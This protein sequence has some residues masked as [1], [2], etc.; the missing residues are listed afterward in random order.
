MNDWQSRVRRHLRE[1]GLT[2][3]DAV[4][5][6][7]ADHLEDAWEARRRR[8]R[9][10]T[11]GEF[12]A[13]ALRRADVMALAARQATPPPP[14]APEPGIRFA[15]SADWAANCA[16]RCGCCAGRRRSPP[17]SSPS[18]PS[19]IGATT[20]AFELVYSA[21]LAPLPYTDADRLVM[22]W[23]HNLTRGRARNVIN[24]GNYFA[25][26]ERSTSLETSGIFA[27]RTGNL[28]GDGG[29]PEELR[30]VAV[31]PQVLGDARGPPVGRPAA[32]AKATMTRARRRPSS[33][34]RGCGDGA[35]AGR[36]MPSAAPW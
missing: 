12:A 29:A 26:S 13:E 21:L 20:A 14:P 23:E 6:E 25:W 22:V 30:G 24:P 35:T 5:E 31:Q 1:R 17:R 3:P 2:L 19:G 33:S 32:G 27:Q 28:S 34:A 10:T 18:S 7:L 11:P 15:R 9:P 16:T 4:V 36:P 8:R